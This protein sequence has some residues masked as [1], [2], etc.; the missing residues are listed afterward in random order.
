MYKYE[1]V[2]ESIFT[3]SGQRMFLSIRDN[4]NDI[5]A[6]AGAV[7]MREAISGQSGDSWLMLACVD[8]MVELGE[9]KEITPA[10]EAGQH[11]IFVNPQG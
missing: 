1:A 3:E 10:G 8:W 7:R 4:V 9:L 11:R 2:R 5:L 6:K